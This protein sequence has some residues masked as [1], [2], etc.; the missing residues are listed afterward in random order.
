MNGKEIFPWCFSGFLHGLWRLTLTLTTRN[1]S[2]L[3]GPL[4]VPPE[5]SS[6]HQRG[7]GRPRQCSVRDAVRF[8]GLGNL[9]SIF[10]QTHDWPDSKFLNPNRSQIRKSQ[11]QKAVSKLP[12]SFC[13]TEMGKP[14]AKPRSKRVIPYLESEHPQILSILCTVGICWGRIKLRPALALL[15]RSF[16]PM[17]S[18][19]RC[20]ARK[21]SGA[22]LV[23]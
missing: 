1:Q 8:H 18:N 9:G 21:T 17:Q 6:P 14:N 7:S 16:S 10:R 11:S 12:T 20:Q 19:L 15:C 23:P 5:S 22:G 3:Q 4:S 13:Q 2:S